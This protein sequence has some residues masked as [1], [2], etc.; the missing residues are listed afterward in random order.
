[1][2][3]RPRLQQ[4][5]DDE[6]TREIMITSISKRARRRPEP[7][8]E[9]DGLDDDS[10]VAL[11]PDD[12]PTHAVSR[13]M[14]LPNEPPAEAR[15]QEGLTSVFCAV[16]MGAALTEEASPQQQPAASPTPPQAA[17]N[18]PR[19]SMGADEPT[20]AGISQAVRVGILRKPSGE[21][22]VRML[23]ADG[24]RAGEH[25]ALVI[26]LRPESDLRTLL[27]R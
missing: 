11:S 22:V 9:S 8:P 6:K 3:S 17:A 4:E 26:A 13:G 25:E 21:A 27:A 15:S 14:P 24:L 2:A 10:E 1:M 16:T 19:A 7:E 12:W 18:P 20:A 5:D 23:E